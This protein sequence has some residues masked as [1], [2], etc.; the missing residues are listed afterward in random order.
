MTLRHLRILYI[1]N[2]AV[3]KADRG[4]SVKHGQTFDYDIPP[5]YAK[6]FPEDKP[7]RSL[8]IEMAAFEYR[9]WKSGDFY[10]TSSY[11]AITDEARIL[12]RGLRRSKFDF[13]QGYTQPEVVKET[14]LALVHYHGYG[15]DYLGYRYFPTADIQDA[16][17]SLCRG[18]RLVASR[19]FPTR[20]FYFLPG[21]DIRDWW[22]K[23][24]IGKREA[25]TILPR[26]ERQTK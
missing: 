23:F 10:G 2:R 26:V 20:P 19:I 24:L 1:I 13:H 15:E 18:R 12:L 3:L 6:V 25:E 7:L 11:A 17:R 16:F 21:A 5:L 22:R 4:S 9:L 8:H 14:M